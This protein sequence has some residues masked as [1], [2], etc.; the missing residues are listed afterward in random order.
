MKR[1][2]FFDKFLYMLDA[3]GEIA[4]STELASIKEWDSLV[5]VSTLALFNRNLGLKVSAS[6]VNNAKTV[7]DILDL[8]SSKY[9]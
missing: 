2:E 9:E 7:G 6:D 5:M 4:E 8:G 1:Q 3:E